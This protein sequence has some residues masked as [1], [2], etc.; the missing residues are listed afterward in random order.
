VMSPVNQSTLRVPNVFAK[1]ADGVA[2]FKIVDAWGEFDVVLDERGLSRLEP[3]YESLVWRAGSII[4]ENLHHD[5]FALDLN[6]ASLLLECFCDGS[7]VAGR[8]A[9]LVASGEKTDRQ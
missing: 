1:K 6:I 8:L 7:G 2:F 5:A 9:R 3:N 4:G